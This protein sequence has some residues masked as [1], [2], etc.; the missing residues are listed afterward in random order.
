MNYYYSLGYDIRLPPA[1]SFLVAAMRGTGGDPVTLNVS[2]LYA[3]AGAYKMLS[4]RI[5]N[6]H[7]PHEPSTLAP[8]TV[9]SDWSAY[10]LILAM[11]MALQAKT[12]A[13]GWAYHLHFTVSTTG[14]L[15]ITASD[16]SSFFYFSG[17]NANTELLL[18]LDSAHQSGI[19][20][21]TR[22][23]LFKMQHLIVPDIQYISNNSGIQEADKMSSI[24]VPD[25]GGE[26]YGL[27]RRYALCTM[28][29]TQQ[30]E[31]Y[32]SMYGNQSVNGNPVDYRRFGFDYLFAHC[33]TGYPFVLAGSTEDT[34]HY[35]RSEGASFKPK[36]M[37]RDYQ[38][39]WELDFRTTY[40]G[41]TLGQ[42][43]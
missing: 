26:P 13:A 9:W 36:P 43:W 1:S 14:H 30:G 33:R 21:I 2:E 22:T 41:T 4:S 38:G 31:S 28:N 37:F 12:D 29:W 3:T 10:S 39:L 11:E 15:V 5:I 40:I 20:T 17:S 32:G 27:S 23:S 35:L 25:S 7:H 6:V 8:S 16:G 42:G 34:I 19:I 18:G 24:A